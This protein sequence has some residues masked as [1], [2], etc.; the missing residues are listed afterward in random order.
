MK[1]GDYTIDIY[2]GFFKGK[3][4]ALEEASSYPP[5]HVHL[6]WNYGIIIPSRRTKFDISRTKFDIPRTKFEISRTKK[7]KEEKK[8][9]KREEEKGG[10]KKRGKRRER[11]EKKEKREKEVN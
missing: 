3:N 5:T 9:K 8:E 7:R 11:G 10:K 1:Y 2:S 6:I 4:S